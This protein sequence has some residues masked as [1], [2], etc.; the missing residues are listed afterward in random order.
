MTLSP[1]PQAIDCLAS[2]VIYYTVLLLLISFVVLMSVFFF[3]LVWWSLFDS[4][5][6]AISHSLL[7]SNVWHVKKVI[8][9]SFSK[10]NHHQCK[11]LPAHFSRKVMITLQGLGI[12]ISGIFIFLPSKMASTDNRRFMDFFLPSIYFYISQG[13]LSF[14]IWR[15]E[16]PFSH[17]I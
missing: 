9:N 1:P 16:K 2:F 14:C 8:K 5:Y 6:S 12:L 4:G 7:K 13:Y 17:R 3:R 10:S 15:Y 11:Y